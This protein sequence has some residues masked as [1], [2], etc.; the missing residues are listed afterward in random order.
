MIKNEKPMCKIG[1]KFYRIVKGEVKLAT[2]IRAEKMLLGHY[3]YGD[4]IKYTEAVFNRNFAK[5]YF[6]DKELAE[7]KIRIKS[8]ISEIKE[9]LK[10]YQEQLEDI[11]AENE[12]QIME[13]KENE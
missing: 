12:K 2:I 4:D 9:T 8:T 1:D 10:E 13:E 11:I 7:E 5:T 3:V 6:K